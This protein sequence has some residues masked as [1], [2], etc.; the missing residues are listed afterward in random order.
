MFFA[1]SG[2]TDILVRWS[3]AGMPVPQN[4]QQ[5]KLFY[6]TVAVRSSSE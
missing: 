3:Q 2:G 5:I 4:V 6:L 1:L